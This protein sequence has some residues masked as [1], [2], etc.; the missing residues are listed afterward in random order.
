[1]D[2]LLSKE[3]DPEQSGV[4]MV[5]SSGSARPSNWRARDPATHGAA[6]LLARLPKRNR[7]SPL[8]E[9]KRCRTP[10][11]APPLARRRECSMR[12]AQ[13]ARE[14]RQ[15][16]RI[17]HCELSIGLGGIAQLVERRL[18]KP[19]VAGSSPTASTNRRSAAA[20]QVARRSAASQVA[21]AER[22]TVSDLRLET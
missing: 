18:C 5:N 21:S 12:N 20:S 1:M 6:S 22:R 2:H 17:A 8:H 10:P 3:T 4:P 9:P 15:A 13:C 11:P 19:N 7:T 14:R 16:L